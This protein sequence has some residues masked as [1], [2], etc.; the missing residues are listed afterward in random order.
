VTE[1]A[2]DQWQTGLALVLSQWMAEGSEATRA[3]LQPVAMGIVADVAGAFAVYPPGSQAEWAELHRVIAARQHGLGPDATS[4]A[5]NHIAGQLEEQLTAYNRYFGLKEPSVLPRGDDYP[6]RIRL[7]LDS[8]PGRPFDELVLERAGSPAAAREVFAYIQ[9]WD[10]LSDE[11]QRSPTPSEYAERWRVSGDTMRQRDAAFRQ[12]FPTETTPERIMRLL[13]SQLPSDGDFI[14]MLGRPVVETDGLPTVINHFVNCLAFELRH[15]H[16]LGSA[17]YRSAFLSD[18]LESSPSRELRRFF[19]LCERA[20]RTWSA[21]ALLAE[22]ATHLVDGLL[23]I[24]GVYDEQTASYAEGMLGEYRRQL[25]Q[26]APR[27][28]LLAA[29]KALR[30]AAAVDVLNPPA[31]TAPYLLGIQWAAK[32]LAEAKADEIPLDPIEEVS[33]VTRLLNAVH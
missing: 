18:D 12:V 30:S 10:R 33:E 24:G 19:A 7:A 2:L 13:W 23:S 26:G 6:P 20:F 31:T 3:Q 11:L 32:A 4:D 28:L 17:V 25:P 22:N 16:A 27:R 8:E 29:Q 9:E 1:E 21:K 5:Q 14:R 15:D